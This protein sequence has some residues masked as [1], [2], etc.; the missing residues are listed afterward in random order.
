[1]KYQI[2]ECAKTEELSTKVNEEISKGWKP[3]G[4]VAIGLSESDEYAYFTIAQAM[5]KE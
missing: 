4:G 1:M 2:V 5:I 3:L